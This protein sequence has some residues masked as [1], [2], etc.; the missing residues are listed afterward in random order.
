ME[1][2]LDPINIV[3]LLVALINTIYGLIV[4]TRNRND[5]TNFSFFI[6]TLSVSFWDIGMFAYRGVA[7]QQLAIFFARLLYFAA[8]TIPFAFLYFV[9]IFPNTEFKPKNWQ[10][11]LVPI[12]FVVL[13]IISLVPGV[14]IE[15]VV[16]IAGKENMI[17]FNPWLHMFYAVYIIFY[18][19]WGYWLLFKKY[20]TTSGI[21][22]IQILYIIVGTLVSTT[23]GVFSNLTL[24][25]FFN[26]FSLNWLGQVGTIVMITSISYSILKY[27]LFNIR[28]IATELFI[29]TLWMFIFIRTLTAE[30]SQE[31][32]LNGILLVLTIIIGVL[33]LRSVLKEVHQREKI[34]LLAADLQKANTR[35]TELDR[36]KSEFVSF[37]TH[38]LRAPLTAMK[39][40]GSMLLEGDM[41][42]LT[43]EARE[44]I[45]RIF[46][47]TI[48]LINIVEDYLNITRIELGTMKYA[49]DTLDLRQLIEDVIAELK[50]SIDKAPV[51]FSF[52]PEENRN[53]RIVAD[54]DKLKQVIAN[55]I[56]N[57]IKYTPSGTVA[58]SLRHDNARRKIIFAIK[59]TGIGI[60]PEVLPRLF[61][62]FSRAQSA[63]KVNIRGTGLGLYVAK[64]IVDAHRGTLHAES[65][66]EGKGST[67]ILEMDPFAKAE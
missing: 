31:K 38:Q 22:R 56:D 42:T 2:K 44:G 66:G 8:S 33:L 28:V 35:L 30:N 17:V 32:I 20:Q 10:K 46:D 62:K 4:F 64:E 63:N 45:S 26:I 53:Y 49:F 15:S 25:L 1:L 13:S 59:D 14:L 36:Q 54:K 50:P 39:W 34:E 61:Q 52:T 24:L 23:I 55:L 9:F 12:P 3:I 47:S 18:F 43:K 65:E 41:G 27:H 6:L 21:L 7:D 11:Y 57:S 60:A 40:Y 37:A 51:K 48:T 58:A 19:C 16:F 67:F 29:F 5:K